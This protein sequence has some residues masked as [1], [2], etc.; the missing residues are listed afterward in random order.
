MS[1][2]TN[3]Y[4]N[5]EKWRDPSLR[6]T[7][8]RENRITEIALRKLRDKHRTEYAALREEAKR[9]VRQQLRDDAAAVARGETLSRFPAYYLPHA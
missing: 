2:K 8:S 3:A 1:D 4:A 5:V 6:G 7:R 9:E